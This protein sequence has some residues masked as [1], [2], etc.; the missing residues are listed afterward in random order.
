MSNRLEASRLKRMVPLLLLTFAGLQACSSS[1]AQ[2]PI[3]PLP[4]GTPSESE[5]FSTQIAGRRAA[6]TAEAQNDKDPNA[7]PLPD[8]V[9]RNNVSICLMDKNPEACVAPITREMYISELEYQL[10]FIEQNKADISQ[11]VYNVISQTTSVL[12][13]EIILNK[14]G[15]QESVQINPFESHF[16][17]ADGGMTK[18]K[19]NKQDLSNPRIELYLPVTDQNLQPPQTAGT[20]MH[21]EFH[22]VISI[23][24]HKLG[25]SI[26]DDEN[27]EG[28]GNSKYKSQTVDLEEYRAQFFGDV[29]E[30]LLAKKTGAIN[31]PE[32]QN[33]VNGYIEKY[34][35]YIPFISA[36]CDKNNIKPEDPL[37]QLLYDSI[38][39]NLNRKGYERFGSEDYLKREQLLLQNWS[40]YPWTTEEIDLLNQMK[41]DGVNEGWLTSDGLPP[42]PSYFK[43]GDIYE[44]IISTPI[45]P[46]YVPTNI[47]LP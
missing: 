15:V 1:Q 22:A 36:W 40:N 46:T 11:Y 2:S 3:L 31:T 43:P 10:Q 26:V 32:Y 18:S 23:L 7:T 44:A 33:V 38:S 16:K 6:Y 39:W 25:S 28:F 8:T 9:R 29:F 20:K 4:F 34:G 12:L 42:S 37:Y 14:E 5:L 19:E 13:Q 45:A 24:R 17:E 41:R 27:A 47:A 35:N 30:I 21:E